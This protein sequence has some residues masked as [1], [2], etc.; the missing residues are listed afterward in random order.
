MSSGTSTNKLIVLDAFTGNVQDFDHSRVPGL[1][2][3][4][5]PVASR[6]RPI[7]VEAEKNKVGRSFFKNREI[8]GGL[9]FFNYCTSL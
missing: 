1:L 2:D 6:K 4:L 5:L 7:V 3:R 8:Q 9:F